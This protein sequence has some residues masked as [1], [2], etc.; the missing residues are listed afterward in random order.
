M[1][2]EILPWVKQSF[3]GTY[4]ACSHRSTYRDGR[5]TRY[6]KEYLDDNPHMHW[7]K[8]D[9]VKFSDGFHHRQFSDWRG[10]FVTKKDQK[11]FWP[12]NP[13]V[14]RWARNQI[15]IIVGRYRKIK[16]KYTTFTDYGIVV[17]LLTGPRIGH[18]RHYWTS[19]PFHIISPFERKLT[20]ALKKKLMPEMVEILDAPYEDTNEGRNI[21]VSRLYYGLKGA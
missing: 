4:F 10:W 18:I 17:M 20:K 7:R 3:S 13:V 16:F 9:I 5:R 8:G 21:L 15:G 1:Q 12:R 6:I 14:S 2:Q 19:H 11:G